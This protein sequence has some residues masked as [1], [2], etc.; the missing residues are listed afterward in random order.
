MV[1][2]YICGPLEYM[3]LNMVMGDVYTHQTLI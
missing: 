3:H 1:I 2:N